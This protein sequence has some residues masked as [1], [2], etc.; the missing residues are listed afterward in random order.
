MGKA[1]KEAMLRRLDDDRSN[2]TGIGCFLLPSRRRKS[3]ILRGPTSL[4]HFLVY[5]ANVSTE[6]SQWVGLCMIPLRIVILAQS[7]YSVAIGQKSA[8]QSEC[9]V[10]N[11]VRSTD[12]KGLI[13]A[14]QWHAAQ[15]RCKM[16][17]TRRTMPRERERLLLRCT[18]DHDTITSTE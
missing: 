8:T 14:N 9:S 7:E 12:P 16:D 18:T 4:W 15:A 11:L 3:S 13:Q 1:M 17:S 10:G 2:G 6:R 5:I